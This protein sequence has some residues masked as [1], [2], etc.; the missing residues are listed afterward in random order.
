SNFQLPHEN[1]AAERSPIEL[2]I[3]GSEVGQLMC[4]DPCQDGLR[5][6]SHSAAAEYQYLP[7]VDAL[8][9]MSH[10][11]GGHPDVVGHRQT[12]LQSD[13]LDPLVQLRRH[14]ARNA[15]LHFVVEVL[16][17]QE[18]NAERP[19]KLQKSQRKHE[20]RQG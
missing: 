4:D 9:Y 20:D 10:R 15:Q 13:G 14:V 19:Q 2:G 12:A 11:V 5:Q 18:Q 6:D 7:S 3:A 17:L 1:L 8:V 16:D